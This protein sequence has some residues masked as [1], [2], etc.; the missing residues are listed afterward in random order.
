[1]VTNRP[2]PLHL[3]LITREDPPLPLARFRANNL[4]T[5]VRAQDLRFS[6]PDAGRF[7]NGALGL[8]LSPA[9]VD[10]LK[11]RTEGWIVGLQLAGLAIRVRADPSDFIAT[12]SGSHRFIL[13]YLTEEVLGRQPEEIQRFLLETSILDNLTATSATRSPDVPTGGTCS[14]ASTAPTSS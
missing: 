7:L 4:L 2:D 9:D 10:A 1:M 3:V 14:N 5:E 12:L 11:E 6:G 8:S 13:S